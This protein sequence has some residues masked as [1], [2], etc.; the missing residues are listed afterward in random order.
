MTPTGKIDKGWGFEIVWASTENYCGK[1][2]CFINAGAK[3]SM[4]FHKDKDETWFVNAGKFKVR[5]I[6]TTTAICHEQ[7]L[8]EGAVWY[9]P[10]LRPHQLEALTND[11]VIFEVSTKDTP[12]DNYRVQP[13]DSQKL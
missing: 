3:M 11:A 5:W 7:I 8:A 4:H 2:L 9:N 1:L 10:P 12:E 13:G 6:D